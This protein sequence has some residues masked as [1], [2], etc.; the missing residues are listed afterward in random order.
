MG[1]PFMSFLP[2]VLSDVFVPVLEVGLEVG[3]EF[4]GVG[5]VDYTVI[6]AEGET[7]NG[8]DCNGVV[9]V[10]VGDD[11][12]LLVQ[13][14]DAQDGA[15]RLVDDRGSKLFAEDAGVCQGEGAA[16]D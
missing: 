11:F 16:G 6:E 12:G 1:L 10:L 14:A 5:S 3:H 2:S 7:L 9:A 15:L 8:A 13:A 4:P